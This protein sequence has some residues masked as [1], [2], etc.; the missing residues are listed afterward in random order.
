MSQKHRDVTQLCCRHSWGGSR[1]QLRS[2]RLSCGLHSRRR[3][4][5]RPPGKP[6]CTRCAA[7][8][9]L[10]ACQ[11]CV[12]VQQDIACSSAQCLAFRASQAEAARVP[13]TKND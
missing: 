7:V 6:T 11:T 2:C 1:R 8:A 10:T 13:D 3:E 4:M 9:T 12:T 5:L